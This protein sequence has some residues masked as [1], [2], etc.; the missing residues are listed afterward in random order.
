MKMVYTNESNFIV[1]NVKN[2]IE[3]QQIATFINNEFAQGAAGEISVF[4]CWPEVW[5]FDDADFDRA[6]DIVNS[7][8]R[9]NNGADWICK[10]CSEEN[11][12][13]FEICW[14]CQQG[15]C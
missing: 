10:N 8:Q 9:N 3:A 12:A 15:N 1:N 13:S 14:R 4:D 2:L 11:D 5:V 7:S 6:V